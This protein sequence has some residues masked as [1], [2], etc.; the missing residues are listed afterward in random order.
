M[1]VEK[2]PFIEVPS[3]SNYLYPG[4]EDKEI[5]KHN[6]QVVGRYINDLAI[7]TRNFD[8]V[9][10][11]LSKWEEIGMSAINGYCKINWDVFRDRFKNNR[12]VGLPEFKNCLESATRKIQRYREN[13]QIQE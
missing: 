3:D 2:K 13:D 1:S 9:D 5:F 10:Q 6:F 7:E 12:E 4:V 11:L 8:D